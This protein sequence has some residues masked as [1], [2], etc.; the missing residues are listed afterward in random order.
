MPERTYENVI[1]NREVS[2]AIE[3]VLIAPYPNS[4]GPTR[5]VF[6]N[7]WIDAQGFDELGAVVDD[8]V[9]LTYTREKFQLMTGIPRVLQYEAVLGVTGRLQGMLHSHHPRRMHF[10]LGNVDPINVVAA[11]TAIADDVPNHATVSFSVSVTSFAVGDEVVTAV[12]SGGLER[13]NNYAEVSSISDGTT[14]TLYFVSPGFAHL[15]N[16]SLGL[17][18][19]VLS[20]EQAFGTSKIK[21]FALV[22]V[23]DFIDGVQLVHYVPRAQ[24]GGELNEKAMPAENFR[25]A[26]DFNIF[27]TSAS[28]FTGAGEQVLVKRFWFPRCTL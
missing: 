8:S 5:V 23:A 21:S 17:I 7:S 1:T 16:G 4:W 10:M 15:P 3:R 11:V 6:D 2:I 18:G 24:P 19:K 20:V 22:G 9:Q 27:G 14:K 13:A 26:M 25:Q 28:E 12:G